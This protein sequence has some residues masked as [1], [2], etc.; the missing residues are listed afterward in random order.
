[1]LNHFFENLENSLLLSHDSTLQFLFNGKC[2]H[3]V[4]YSFKFRNCRGC[5][6]IREKV[7]I[8]ESVRTTVVIFDCVVQCSECFGENRKC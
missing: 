3:V 6:H 8:E 1:M 7:K 2:F 5:I 4:H